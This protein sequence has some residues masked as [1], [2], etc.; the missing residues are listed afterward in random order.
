MSARRLLG[1]YTKLLAA[2]GPRSWWPADSPEEVILGAI[3]TQNTSWANVR[4]ALQALT[5]E[6]LLGFRQIADVDEQ[7][8]ARL[9]RSSGYFNQKAR[10]IKQFASYF[11][12][13]Y[14]YSIARMRKRDVHSLRDELLKQYRIGPETADCIL[15]YALGMPV[16]VIDAYTRR[17]LSRHG[18]LTMQ[19]DYD[20][21][22]KLFMKHLLPD[23]ALYND[24]HAQLVHA[25]NLY[26]K[27]KPL[28][29]QCP[30]REKRAFKVQQFK[31]KNP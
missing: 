1:M 25:G 9:V 15:L 16:F 30:L 19:H 4:K 5:E 24:F 12:S 29:E 3:L 10:A 14:G 17:I 6:G 20:D 22:Q 11:G 28:C 21:Y 2:F 7:D 31:V 26:C 27:P 8:L 18:I 23:V 13:A